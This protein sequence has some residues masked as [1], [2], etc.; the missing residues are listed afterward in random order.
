MSFGLKRLDV[1]DIER[2]QKQGV[3]AEEHYHPNIVTDEKN[4]LKGV[5][6]KQRANAQKASD[7][8]NIKSGTR[9]THCGMLHFMWRENCATCKKP[10]DYNLGVKE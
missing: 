4:P 10:M 8:L 7:V 3:R 1:E 2:L 9:C 6:T 5:I